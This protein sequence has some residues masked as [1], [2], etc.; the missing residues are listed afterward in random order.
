M[1]N[2]QAPD[3]APP[4]L[5]NP[6]DLIA[7]KAAPLDES[8][9]E[10]PIDFDAQGGK[11]ERV[12]QPSQAFT[13]EQ[14]A[15][16]LNAAESQAAENAD[17]LSKK[18]ENTDSGSIE[19]GENTS[20][21]NFKYQNPQTGK[22]QAKGKVKG[23]STK[24]KI[25]TMLILS[26]LGVGG[27][28]VGMFGPQMLFFNFE[29]ALTSKFN[30]QLSGMDQRTN[31]LWGTKLSGTNKTSCSGAKCQF[32]TVTKSQV[33][34]MARSGVEAYTSSGNPLWTQNAD[35]TITIAADNNIELSTLRL[36]NGSVIT[37]AG[38]PVQI[39][40]Q[41]SV[42]VDYNSA[43][44]S[45]SN[46]ADLHGV[47][48]PKF[49]GF[50]DKVAAK[51]RG[52]YKVSKSDTIDVE[53]K[54]QEEIDAQQTYN[55]AQQAAQQAEQNLV[56]AQ[57]R[58][59]SD[60][61]SPD[62]QAAVNTAQAVKTNADLALGVARSQLETIQN[63]TVNGQRMT[64]KQKAIL[65]I[66]QKITNAVESKFPSLA[67]KAQ[68]A[69][70]DADGSKGGLDIP[71]ISAVGVAVDFL[72]D[73]GCVWY[74]RAKTLMYSLKGA[75]IAILL[76]QFN[77]VF[78]TISKI[79]AG[80]HIGERDVETLGTLLTKT[81]SYVA[82]EGA[83]NVIRTTQSA[84]D[85]FGYKYAKYGNLP[86]ASNNANMENPA[87]KAFRQWQTGGDYLGYMTSGNILGQGVNWIAGAINTALK[88]IDTI[89]QI[90]LGT[91][92]VK[93]NAMTHLC[94][95]LMSNAA[96][97]IE[98]GLGLG[99]CAAETATTILGCLITT[100][101]GFVARVVASM[102][103]SWAFS[104]LVSFVT[105]GI[106]EQLQDNLL[107]GSSDLMGNAL[108]SGAGVYLGRSAGYGG[109]A[110]VNKTQAVNVA[111]DLRDTNLAYAEEDRVN[112]SPFDISSPNT[113][114]GSIAY[115]L[116]PR[117]ASINGAWSFMTTFSSIISGG[118]FAPLS[119]AGAEADLTAQFEFCNASDDLFLREI[120]KDG[121]VALD[122]YCNPV[123]G[124]PD[125]P[126]DIIALTNQLESADHIDAN[127]EPKSDIFKDFIK[128]C[129]E[130]DPLRE[131]GFGGSPEDNWEN[132][133]EDCKYG[134]EYHHYKASFYE[135]NTGTPLD[136]LNFTGIFPISLRSI[137]DNSIFYDYLQY[138][139][140]N[141]GMNGN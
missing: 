79:K 6:E 89:G 38:G 52:D 118:L 129:I 54:T 106:F 24:K 47:Y 57:G 60:P 16:N 66:S 41:T 42:S 56:E 51:F 139:R 61:S 11:V 15:D 122:P 105:K 116:I 50:S 10:S 21:E 59:A 67:T 82:R 124:Y 39:N 45:A 94:R 32:Q 8:G 107:N 99:G 98:L 132:D 137:P 92:G 18:N 33:E 70:S 125:A 25:T 34:A 103:G 87:V 112:R 86:I 13:P 40:G 101:V 128:V 53:E 75:Q 26:V 9:A 17:E 58:L 136:F 77:L 109:N 14:T 78:S 49:M 130:R 127:G 140:I 135:I 76:Q 5:A 114:M 134:H 43:I 74:S 115:D 117:F 4:G 131:F 81:F 30:Y 20:G 138:K 110:L 80:E 133:G 100:I 22:G 19:K 123:Y 1:A 95:I 64:L 96:D 12:E 23:K 102:A 46:R 3:Q 126:R 35:G 83:A 68:R 88:G 44:K 65:A 141:D 48:N 111:R 104:Q 120:A 27:M 90:A 28:G 108:A 37:A 36:P 119:V 97:A 29:N 62:L 73:H 93:S 91:F 55:E 71:G 121:D 85:S 72:S 113:F 7:R 31:L 84:T 2:R 69:D 63:P